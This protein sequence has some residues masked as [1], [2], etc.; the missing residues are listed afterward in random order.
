MTKVAK[1]SN[2]GSKPGERRGGRQTGTPNKTT[3]A[4]KE[5]LVAA[6]DGM[7]GV[8][9]LQSWATDNPTEFYKLWAKL[10]PQDVNANIKG[11]ISVIQLVGVRPGG[12]S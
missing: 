6:F 12:G 5:A 8:K 7:G 11:D 10:L 9:K 4:V 2:R 3:V 1:N